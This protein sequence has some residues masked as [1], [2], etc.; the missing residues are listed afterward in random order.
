[1]FFTTVYTYERDFSVSSEQ[2]DAGV[3]CVNLFIFMQTIFL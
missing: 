2:E 1:M 3:V